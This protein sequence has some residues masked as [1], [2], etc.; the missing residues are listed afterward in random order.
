MPIRPV[1][2]TGVRGTSNTRGTVQEREAQS[3]KKEAKTGIASV[4]DAFENKAGD[5]MVDRAVKRF[6]DR[7][8]KILGNDAMGLA[9]RSAGLDPINKEPTDAQVTAIKAAAVD[10]MKD[11]PVRALAPDAA[12]A[13]EERLRNQGVD[14]SGLENKKLSELGDVGTSAAK[15]MVDRFKADHPKAFYG[16]AAGA[17]IGGAVYAYDKGSDA[18]KKL[19]IKPEV[20]KK[21]GDNTKVDLKAKW[22]ERFATYEASGDASHT[23][24]GDGKSTSVSAGTTV[25]GGGQE[26]LDITSLRLGITH[27][28]KVGES[29]RFRTSHRAEIKGDNLRMTNRVGGSTQ[30]GDDWKLSGDAV[31]TS[32]T[33]YGEFQARNLKLSSSLRRSGLALNSK[34][35]VDREGLKGVSSRLVV[36]TGDLTLNS[37]IDVDRE[38][39]KGGSSTLVVNTGDQGKARL[40]AGFGRDLELTSLSAGYELNKTAGGGDLYVKGKADYDLRLEKLGAELSAGYR[41]D[42]LDIGVVAGRNERLGN[43]VGAGLKWSF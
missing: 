24:K 13:I 7:T 37:K 33:E 40:G 21:L 26:G 17:A 22:T 19:G 42:N 39:L 41:K 34:I 23:F 8:N 15:Q 3:A 30:L 28:R 35:D 25:A 10:M 2:S 43:Y 11:M 32:N 9:R 6:A 29:S 12:R 18:L 38:G 4:G 5:P 36:N 16:L 14:V 27:D 1:S 31:L 20:S